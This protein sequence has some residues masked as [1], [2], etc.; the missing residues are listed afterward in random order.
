[1]IGEGRSAFQTTART[2]IRNWGDDL[3]RSAS[4]RPRNLNGQIRTRFTNLL[5]WL[6]PGSLLRGPTAILFISRDT[7]SDSIAKLFRAC[8]PGVSHTYHAIC[9]KTGYR[10]DKAPRG[11][12]ARCWGIAGM[13]D[14]VSRDRGYRIATALASYRVE[15]P[16]NPENRRKIGKK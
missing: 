13:A 10:T 8:F 6:A 14:K 16:G 11:G 4:F 2:M 15:K 12:I 1:M 5:I 9:C 3:H 7:F